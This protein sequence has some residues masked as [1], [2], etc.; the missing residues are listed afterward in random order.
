MFKLGSYLNCK[1]FIFASSSSVYGDGQGITKKE[2]DTLRPI[3]PYG[4]SKL[5]FEKYIENISS[6]KKLKSVGLRFFNV[7]GPRQSIKGP[8]QQ[9]LLNGLIVVLAKKN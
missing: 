8:M 3:S 9:L 7:F 1:R 2:S 5:F 6:N 4:L